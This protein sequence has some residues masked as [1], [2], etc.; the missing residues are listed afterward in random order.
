M[1]DLPFGHNHN[2]GVVVPLK[3]CSTGSKSLPTKS[4]NVSP[5]T[6]S[7]TTLRVFIPPLYIVTI[8]DKRSPRTSNLR[9]TQIHRQKINNHDCLAL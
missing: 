4:A 2:T 5:S 1:R 8:T 3:D 6:V 7:G 9:L